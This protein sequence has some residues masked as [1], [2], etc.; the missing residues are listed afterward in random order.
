[1]ALELA[2]QASDL[3]KSEEEKRACDSLMAEIYFARALSNA[4]QSRVG[5]LELAV[6]LV[7]EK[8]LYRIHLA[9]ALEQAG[10]FNKA[11]AHYQAVNEAAECPGVGYLWCV[12]ALQAGRPLPTVDL[13][14]AEQNTLKIAQH[15]VT[16]KPKS[17][18]PAEPVLDGSLPLW[19]ALAQMVADETAAPIEELKRAAQRL[20]GTDAA[21]IAHYLVG[22][23]ALRAGDPDMAWQALTDARTFGYTSAWLEENF[24]NLARARAIQRAESG[25]W[26]GTIDAA[27]PILGEGDDRILAETANLAYFHL[28][29]TA[30]QAGD[31]AAATRH[32][33]QAEHYG[34]HRYLSQNLALAH[35]QQEDWAGAA[36]AWRD[37][38]RRRPRK[39]NHPDYL[40][41]NQAAA[42]WRHAAE[43]YKRANN[44]PEAITCLRNA[45]KFAPD[46]IEMRRELSAALMAN[47][48]LEAAETELNR[49]LKQDP[50]DI[51]ALVSLG[52]LYAIDGRWRSKYQVAEVLK[53]AL[54]LDPERTDAR[55]ILATH[56]IEQGHSYVQWG[57]YNEAIKQYQQGLKD[58]P[59]HALLYVSLAEAERD[60]GD[61]NAAREHLFQ[62]YDLEPDRTRTVGRVLHE[63]LHLEADEDVERLLPRARQIPGVLPAFWTSQ[64]EQVLECELDPN[65]A[66]RFFDE[67][68]ALVGQEWVTETRAEVL[69]DIVIGLNS[70]GEGKSPL[71]RT[72][73]KRIDR[74]V[75]DSGAKELMDGLTA[76][77]EQHNLGKAKR[78]LEKAR[79]KARRAGEHGLVD[80]IEIIEET[81]LSGPLGLFDFLDRI[82]R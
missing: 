9:H 2:E 18:Q 65:W 46:D 81:I 47:E 38:I 12:A 73:R 75:P 5:D 78:L 69:V 26:Q 79:D 68:V 30:A 11:L 74:E 31:W 61:E 76:I 49:I 37:L 45:L 64:A 66:E 44:P 52:Q 13:A 55:E 33:Q 77:F 43:C 58:V 17:M 62:A 14:P 53:R 3:A 19:R 32:W 4:D 34:S 25:D 48:Q 70:A 35:E 42:L 28:G 23:A 6:L 59:N 51:E 71:E 82:L 39:K 60:Q 36:E 40:D 27:A 72:Y 22:V 10:Q 7:P 67:A 57:M 21:G 24:G 50:E 1:V 15:L 41:N 56:Y 20:K 54:K 80:R 16:G 63:L 8:S 29:Y